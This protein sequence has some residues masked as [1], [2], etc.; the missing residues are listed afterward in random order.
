MDF[1]TMLHQ[2]LLSEF[3]HFGKTACF[4]LYS[5]AKFV[6]APPGDC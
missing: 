2:V 5:Q 6:F 3:Q 1:V 4:L